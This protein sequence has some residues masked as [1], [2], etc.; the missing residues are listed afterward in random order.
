M[1]VLR[2]GAAFAG[3]L[4][5]GQSWFTGNSTRFD[6]SLGQHLHRTPSSAGNQRIYTTS[7]WTQMYTAGKTSSGGFWGVSDSNTY[8]RISFEGTIAQGKF[9]SNMR[10]TGGTNYSP[11]GDAQCRDNAWYHVCLGVDST[12]AT[13]ADR[14][15]LWINGVRQDTT[16]YD[17][18]Y[19]PQNN[20]T[21]WMSTSKLYI[22]A[23]NGLANLL[24]ASLAE[25]YILDGIVLD[26]SYFG[27]T[28]PLTGVWRPKEFTRW[29]SDDGYGVNWSSCWSGT[30][31]THGTDGGCFGPDSTT[32]YGYNGSGGTGTYITFTPPTPISISSSARMFIDQ[33]SSSQCTINGSSFTTAAGWN[34]ITSHCSG[35][36]TTIKLDAGAGSAWARIWQLEIDGVVLKDSVGDQTSYLPFDGKQPIGQDMSGKNNDWTPLKFGSTIGMD[37]ATPGTL[38]ILNTVSGGNIASP[39]VRTDANSAN[40]VLALPLCGIKSDFSGE[41]NSGTTSK[42]MTATNSVASNVRSNFYQGSWYFDGSG[43]YL[44]AAANSDFAFGTGDFT[45]EMWVYPTALAG[46]FWDSGAVN[47]NNNIA[48]F[49]DA[50]GITIRM[51]PGSDLQPAH[52]ASGYQVDKWTHMCL[53]RDSGTVKLYLDGVFQASVSNTSDVTATAAQIGLLTG[54]GGSYDFAGWIQDVKVYKGLAKYKTAQFKPASTD[55]IIRPESFNGSSL[56][57]QLMHMPNGAVSFNND[58]YLSLSGSTDTTLGST[59]FTME[60]WVF[61]NDAGT[62]VFFEN[63][64]GTGGCSI[65]INGSEQASFQIGATNVVSTEALGYRKWY[66]LCV[67]RDNSGGVTYCYVDGLKVVSTT[68]DAGSSTSTVSIGAR[69]D[70]SFGIT[71]CISNARL[72]KGSRVYGTGNGS[73]TPPTTALTNVTNTKLLC[74]QSNKDNNAYTVSPGAITANGDV[75]AIAFNPFDGDMRMSTAVPTSHCL[76]SQLDTSGPAAYTFSDGNLTLGKT[77]DEGWYIAAASVAFTPGSGKWQWEFTPHPTGSGDNPYAVKAGWSPVQNNSAGNRQG[78]AGTLVYDMTSGSACKY[79]LDT[80]SQ[81]A[82]GTEITTA[83]TVCTLALDFEEMVARFAVNGVPRPTIDISG[84]GLLSSGDLTPVMIG[85]YGHAEN[86]WLF[87]FG[88][89]PFKYSFGNGYKPINIANTDPPGQVVPEDYF[90]ATVYNGSSATTRR[91]TG[92]S[93]DLVWIKSYHDNVGGW[94]CLDTVRG[95]SWTSDFD[96]TSEQSNETGNFVSFDDNGVTVTGSANAWN[97]LGDKFCLFAWKAGGSSAAFN[98]D[99]AGYASA[100]AAGLDG[101]SINPTGSSVNTTCG[102]SILQYEGTGSNGTIAH[103][104]GRTPAFIIAR[105]LDDTGGTYDWIIY[106]ESV[107]NTKRLKWANDTSTSTSSTFWQDTSPTDELITIGTSNDINKSG[108]T[109]IL[110]AWANVPGLQQF[111]Q[112]TGDNVADGPM[113]NTG[114][115]PAMLFTK[116]YSNTGKW[117]NR[118]INRSPINPSEKIMDMGSTAKDE[119]SS[120]YSMDILATGAKCRSNNAAINNGSVIYCAWA[121][122]PF[123][124][125]YGAQSNAR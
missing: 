79:Q 124:N 116:R 57:S 59:D 51:K 31:P 14:W 44:A 9:T 45:I 111:G 65:Q 1:A 96:S 106:H 64:T 90:S 55:P 75:Q 82:Y 108:D 47:T 12:Q 113:F 6:S 78:T 122:S 52:S 69:S 43:D 77:A 33:G 46:T 53:M 74:C 73:F 56:G 18:G 101:G 16:A 34:D 21:D 50:S 68:T 94:H 110:Y 67:E 22:G 97:G 85:Y 60:C 118:D 32:S 27:Y 70:G 92:F 37:E 11:A 7:F 2:A 3:T 25:M 81:T 83:G 72:V 13:A 105:N 28:D 41:I 36:L 102:L 84:S 112:Y 95:A 42:V 119:D 24:D 99:G 62:T 5:Q 54:F 88:Q 120:D 103:G 23:N 89:K 20:D 115:S 35:T 49:S 38:P 30:G 107:G 63:D 40:L 104:M 19:V 98:R 15:K 17:S 117:C 91:I 93:P 61:F 125:L 71:G 26:A 4:A 8:F 109:Y 10:G 80:G 29:E 87:N 39:G 48:W 76:L 86:K 58:D 123:H 100:A 66:H 121:K 114:F